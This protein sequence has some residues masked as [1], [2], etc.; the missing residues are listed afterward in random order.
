MLTGSSTCFEIRFKVAS[1]AGEVH[2]HLKQRDQ[3]G[4][5]CR[6]EP[7]PEAQKTRSS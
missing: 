7:F 1:T 3:V 2:F 5:N 4:E 6:K